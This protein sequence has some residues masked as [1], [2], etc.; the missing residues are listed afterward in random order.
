M[1]V[2][3]AMSGQRVCNNGQLVVLTHALSQ[4]IHLSAPFTVVGTRMSTPTHT[5]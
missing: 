2:P 4:W 3:L 1:D 5:H